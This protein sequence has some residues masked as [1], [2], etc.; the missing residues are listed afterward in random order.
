MEVTAPPV[1]YEG[2]WRSH[3]KSRR[4]LMG[5]RGDTGCCHSLDLPVTLNK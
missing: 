2:M 4:V 5:K 1:P 3:S